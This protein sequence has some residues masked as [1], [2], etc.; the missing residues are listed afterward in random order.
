VVGGVRGWG[1]GLWSFCPLGLVVVFYVC[2]YDTFELVGVG[3]EY[4][5]HFSLF[6]VYPHCLLSS[7][8]PTLRTITGLRI[9]EKREPHRTLSSFFLSPPP[10]PYF[11]YDKRNG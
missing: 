8:R 5:I 1:S 6:P 3:E 9:V 2:V 10:F 11:V 7:S 4:F